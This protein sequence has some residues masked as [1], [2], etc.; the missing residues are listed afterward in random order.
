MLLHLVNDSI[1]VDKAYKAF[2]AAY[3]GKNDFLMISK[4]GSLKN[5]K[6][7]PVKILTIN[8]LKRTGLSTMLSKYKAVIIHYLNYWS[9]LV[10]GCLPC[11]TKILWVGWGGDYYSLFSKNGEN[12]FILPKTFE[13][14]QNC[15]SLKAKVKKFVSNVQNRFYRRRILSVLGRINYFSPVLEAEYD[16]CQR[17]IKELK[18]DYLP[19]NYGCLDDYIIPNVDLSGEDLLIGNSATFTNNHIEAFALLK[20]IETKNKIIVPLNYGNS[21]YAKIISMEGKK[22]WDKRFICLENF[23]IFPDYVKAISTCSNVFMNHVRQQGLGNIILFLYLGAKI[24][25]R[26]ENLIFSY[27]KSKG[28]SVFSLNNF[29]VT[30]LSEINWSPEMVKKNREIL[31]QNWD[32]KIMNRKTLEIVSI[33]SA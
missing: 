28:A 3:P 22:I 6:L 33:L 1:F 10:I 31:F 25:L 30:N 17:N 8:E 27:L 23:L 32:K 12:D 15:L 9:S 18:A 7:A 5:I 4:V 13:L 24:F 2:E 20:S 16:L 26:E 29:N 14:M 11:S 19:W 21:N